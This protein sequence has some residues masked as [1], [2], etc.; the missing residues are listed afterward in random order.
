[1]TNARVS[2]P[3]RDVAVIESLFVK[4]A[5]V[6]LPQ[7][8]KASADTICFAQRFEIIEN[9]WTNF[10]SLFPKS[11]IAVADQNCGTLLML[12]PATIT[13]LRRLDPG[14]LRLIELTLPS[15][16]TIDGKELRIQDGMRPGSE[17]WIEPLNARN[18]DE[19]QRLYFRSNCSIH[20][21]G[22]LE[23]I[24]SDTYE[25]SDTWSWWRTG[26]LREG[27]AVG[28]RVEGDAGAHAFKIYELKKLALEPDS[29][30]MKQDFVAIAF[31]TGIT[32]FLAQIRYMGLFEFGRA[33]SRIAQGAHFVLVVSVREPRQLICHEELLA[34]ED[35]FPENFRYH[36]AL[37]REWGDSWPYTRNRVIKMEEG[38]GSIDISPL[39]DI[40]P[41]IERRHLRLCGGKEAISQVVKGLHEHE[42]SPLSIKAEV[43]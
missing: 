8:V 31:S 9:D 1:M 23:T 16:L 34:A 18:S 38:S 7:V 40:V 30:W 3:P 6:R 20:A 10:E 43:S 5:S 17:F 37:T 29:W 25:E 33:F 19:R 28:V 24:I 27:D 41:D 42:I 14:D 32:P 21:H 26:G 4:D 11:T 2:H 36:P 22:V 35:R 15:S 12:V 39:I 13:K